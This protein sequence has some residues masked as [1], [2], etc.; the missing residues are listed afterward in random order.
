MGTAARSYAE[1]RLGRDRAMAPL[2]TALRD[3]LGTPTPTPSLKDAP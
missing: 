1:A 3:L 2:E